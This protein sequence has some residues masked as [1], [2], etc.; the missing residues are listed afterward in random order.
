MNQN[1]HEPPPALPRRPRNVRHGVG[2]Y[3]HT[4]SFNRLA[5][6]STAPG[7]LRPEG[8]YLKWRIIGIVAGTVFLLVGLSSVLF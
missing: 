1:S 6:R 4:G 7:S 8:F 5:G 3:L 2:R